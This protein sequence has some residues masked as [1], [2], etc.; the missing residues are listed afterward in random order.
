MQAL[1]PS[2]ESS[3]LPDAA[4]SPQAW[5][6]HMMISSAWENEEHKVSLLD[7]FKSVTCRTL[8]IPATQK[9]LLQDLSQVSLFSE[10]ILVSMILNTKNC[11]LFSNFDIAPIFSGV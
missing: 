4:A 5:L 3:D 11:K 9:R 1:L 7:I 2:D 10:C 8:F 6:H